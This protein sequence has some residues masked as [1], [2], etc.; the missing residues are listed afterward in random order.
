MI[1]RISGFARSLFV[2]PRTSNAYRKVQGPNRS[3]VETSDSILS[4]ATF[5]S[6][7][8]TSRQAAH[9]WLRL[10]LNSNI[11][12]ACGLK[13]AGSSVA[14]SVRMSSKS[15]SSIV[16]RSRNLSA[17]L[18]TRW[19]FNLLR[20]GRYQRRSN[21]IARPLEQ[22]SQGL[23]RSNPLRICRHAREPRSES[24]VC[25]SRFPRETSLPCS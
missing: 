1:F 3:S 6:S 18:M 21:S 20:L 9:S 24:S 8:E 12:S 17:G 19:S 11:F 23:R 7:S 4:K 15:Y 22:L 14:T 13:T 25:A 2:A 10:F 16:F 5:D